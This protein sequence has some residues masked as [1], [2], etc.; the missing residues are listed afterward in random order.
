MSDGVETRLHSGIRC[1]ARR[2][3][4]DVQVGASSAACLQVLDYPPVVF[5]TSTTSNIFG[6]V[7]METPRHEIIAEEKLGRFGQ[8]EEI[9]SAAAFLLS[10]DASFITGHAWSSTVGT[11]PVGTM[12]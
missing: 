12:G 4:R 1:I 9:A 8:P 11:R 2:D 7:G 3:T 6:L 10:A 5:G